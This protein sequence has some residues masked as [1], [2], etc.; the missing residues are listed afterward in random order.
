MMRYIWLILL[1]LCATDVWGATYYVT[2]AGSGGD[3][4][5]TYADSDDITEFNAGGGVYADLE[6]DIVYF[7]DTITTAI[8]IPVSGSADN[9]VTLRGDEAT[10]PGTLDAG[11]SNDHC[12]EMNGTDYIVID[13]FTM[14]DAVETAVDG[15]GASTNISVQNCTF[16]GNDNGDVDIE[17]SGNQY[18]T[19]DNNTI[20]SP[21]DGIGIDVR[22]GADNITIT[23][24]TITGGA[25]GIRVGN[26]YASQCTD[27]ATPVA[28]CSGLDV[29][30]CEVSN[31]I[32]ITG[33]TID[34]SGDGTG[35]THP[36]QVFVDG[37][38]D[39][40]I[41][42]NNI[43]TNPADDVD[44]MELA[45]QGNPASVVVDGNTITNDTTNDGDYGIVVD[46]FA[47]GVATITNNYIEDIPS[48][49]I[50]LQ[51]SIGSTI[52][53]NY[54]KDSGF[55]QNTNC[56][57]SVIPWNCCTGS[58]TG[59]CEEFPAIDI[60]S[61]D[62]LTGE[63]TVE[64]VNIYYNVI[65]GCGRGIGLNVRDALTLDGTEIYN[66]T[67]SGVYG[68]YSTVGAS[69]YAYVTSGTM[70]GLTIRNNI[71]SNDT[72]AYT[73]AVSA[74]AHTSF[75]ASNNIYYGAS[76]NGWFFNGSAYADIA[77]WRTNSGDTITLVSDP[78]FVSA[79]TDFHLT[80]ASP[81][82]DTGTDVSLSTDYDGINVPQ[83]AGVDS[84]AYEYFGTT[85]IQG[86][87]S[88]NG[89]TIQ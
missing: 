44:C 11:D 8:V 54:I 76:T 7:C 42:S 26:N 43:V 63:S 60:E 55:A 14:Q 66:N 31:N 41:V 52:A 88:L 56:T 85:Y 87:T 51:G 58:G 61:R 37:T 47:T 18:W 38:S 4:G 86:A 23:N 50:H 40:Y 15:I 39:N 17:G 71:I 5:S 12:I 1:M 29:G 13:G 82:K 46:M 34:D 2:Q 24:N 33:N 70:S 48:G 77:D 19:V 74:G 20:T 36:I 45:W 75:A 9:L 59:T 3:D 22:L 32:T 27:V 68:D 49:G 35:T 78:A 28:C 53:Y 83:G 65:D 16:T 89:V 84:G 62:F 64:D 21:T 73:I 6:N 67:I 30:T 25:Y 80:S 81:A 79:G 10:Y 69:I 57:D 72:P